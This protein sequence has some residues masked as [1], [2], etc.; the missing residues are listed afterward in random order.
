MHLSLVVLHLAGAVM[1]LLWAVR[2]VRTGVERA[3]GSSLR[4]ALRS[5]R[6]GRLQAAAAG[7]V[8]AVLLQSSTAVAML[9]AGFAAS[10][11]LPVVTGLSALLGADVGSA[12]VVQV[13]SFDLSWL[14]PV[15]LIAGP[16]LFLKFDSR[17]LK[18]IGRI[19]LGIALILLS[20]RLIGE[21]TEPLRHSTFLPL[22]IQ[23]LRGDFIT[24]FALAAGFAWLIHSSVAA[25]LLFAAFA[26][27]GMLPVE[28]GVAFVLG[29]N[30]G[31]GAISVWLTRNEPAIARRIPVGNLCFRATA[32][33]SALLAYQIS[34]FPLD[35]LGAGEARQLINF[36]L[37]FNAVLLVISLPLA[38]Y[39]A[40]LM[41]RIV[42]DSGS[43]E[44][45]D[46][47]SVRISALDPGVIA[48]P[49]LALA[50]ATRELLRM[51]ETVEQMLRPVMDVF[52]SGN[53]EQVARVRSLDREVN[54]A[55]TGIKLFIAKVN[56]GQLSEDE[57]RRGI[58][59]T[60]FAINLE[61]IGDIIAKNL[62][63]L[64]QDKTDKRLSFSREGWKEMNAL[65]ARV[66]ANMQLALNVL[67]SEDLESARQL[68]R[69]KELMRKLE[70]DSHQRHL[71]RLQSGMEESIAT[72]DIHLEVVR[73]LKEINSLLVTVAY[74]LLSQ[75]G[76]LLE[77]R[78][79]ASA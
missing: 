66:M 8:L 54:R 13:L 69:E 52:E 27:Q 43:S 11:I 56:S 77:S 31:A 3:A 72:S 61:H 71:A 50:S 4:D 6:A 46:L 68:V 9:A 25:L 26:A 10:G 64:V 42:R 76:D 49:N 20:L 36:H 33:V 22:A 63:R 78:L 51:G 48:Q 47:A 37:L 65:H 53:S 15:L 2:M 34:P 41:E 74:P 7:T 17:L 21:A 29:A 79:A 59:L 38:G 75:S 16:V 60:D 55:H 45:E 70:R 24:A 35:V 14:M 28:V 32:A 12:L 62:M 58:E 19:L 57:A 67:V 73:G 23:Y 40:S 30:L 18:Q 1:L 44:I 5:A 39:A